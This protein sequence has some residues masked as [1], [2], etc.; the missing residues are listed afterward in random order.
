MNKRTLR[1]LEYFAF[2]E[3]FASLFGLVFALVRFLSLPF[4]FWIYWF[5]FFVVFHIF[6]EIEE[7]IEGDFI[8]YGTP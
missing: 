1:L 7:L 4:S 8:E 6:A 3:G 2:L 5:F